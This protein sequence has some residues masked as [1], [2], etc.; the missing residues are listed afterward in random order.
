MSPSRRTITAVLL[1]FTVAAPAD[2]AV[3]GIPADKLAQLRQLGFAVVPEQPPSG[4][5][6]K[7]A[8]VDPIAES[9]KVIYVRSGDGA[10]ITFTGRKVT[11]PPTEAPHKRHGLFN[12]ISDAVDRLGGTRPTSAPNNV[13]KTNSGHDNTAGEAEAEMS[14]VTAYSPVL[15]PGRFAQE[16][17]C[18]TGTPDPAQAPIKTAE[19]HMT[20]CNLARPDALTRA[21]R[22]LVRVGS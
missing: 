2:A 15:G 3:G 8:S 5:R 21:Y 6:Y 16:H 20:G 7:T 17:G 14:G 19:Y 12:Q 18:L 4:F 22:S 9:Y 13:G 11:S 1:A 10:T